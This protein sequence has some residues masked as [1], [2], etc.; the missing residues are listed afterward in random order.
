M[1][2]PLLFL[3]Q[4]RERERSRSLILHPYVR[5]RKLPVALFAVVLAQVY[6]FDARVRALDLA[7]PLA[8]MTLAMFPLL[9]FTSSKVRMGNYR[10]GKFLLVAGW[11]SCILITALDVY[12]L[13]GMLI[14]AIRGT[15]G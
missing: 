12:G 13:G 11:T 7:R 9:Q 10:N 8:V 14:D 6:A 4:I 3:K 2:M 1:T 5:T 15:G